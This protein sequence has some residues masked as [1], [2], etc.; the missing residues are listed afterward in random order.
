MTEHLPTPLTQ[1]AVV[2]AMALQGITG[3][4]SDVAQD[5]DQAQR[6]TRRLSARGT[7]YDL[8][9]RLATVV[10][11]AGETTAE[12]LQAAAEFFRESPRAEL[13]SIAWSRTPG[14]PGGTWE[15]TATLTVAF[16]DE[17]GEYSGPLQHGAER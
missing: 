17:Q 12:A 6:T 11:C 14:H 4:M 2:P 15:Y 8:S 3:L 13:Q 16:P 10:H 5:F 7:D 1:A 9:V